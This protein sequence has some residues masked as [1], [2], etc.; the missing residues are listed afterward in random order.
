MN[1]ITYLIV[2]FIIFVFWI[3]TW[4]SQS[5]TRTLTKNEAC[6]LQNGSY[7]DIPNNNSILQIN[8]FSNWNTN[9]WIIKINNVLMYLIT[10]I[11]KENNY[12]ENYF[13]YSYDCKTKKSKELLSNFYFSKIIW[14]L[15]HP[16]LTIPTQILWF[17][18]NYV[19]IRFDL[20]W[21]GC[22]VESIDNCSSMDYYEVNINFTTNQF[23]LLKRN[24]SND[25]GHNL[26]TFLLK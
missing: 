2:V 24:T 7:L 19:T 3:N 17:W 23:T 15:E 9:K 8:G 5:I 16:N 20:S 6:K 13:L 22:P 12:N 10:D 21:I 14:K 25:I 4:Y 18:K 1:K 26:W 11:S